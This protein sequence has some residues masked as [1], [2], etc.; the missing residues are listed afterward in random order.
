MPLVVSTIALACSP[1]MSSDPT[2]IVIFPSVSEMVCEIST[3]ELAGITTLALAFGIPALPQV[4]ALFQRLSPAA[5]CGHPVRVVTFAGTGGFGKTATFWAL[6]V[7][8]VRRSNQHV[9]RV[10]S[11]TLP[12]AAL[13]HDARRP[14]LFG[15]SAPAN[16]R[17]AT[18]QCAQMSTSPNEVASLV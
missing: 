18:K 17:R 5:K 12:L 7:L 13:D 4:V 15:R 11:I 1:M 6:L 8:T 16:A 14:I 10:Q 2:G 3:F 9:A